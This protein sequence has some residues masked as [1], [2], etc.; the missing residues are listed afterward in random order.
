MGGDVDTD[1][2]MHTARSESEFVPVNRA[3]E[4]N[5]Y[6]ISKFVSPLAA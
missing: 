5:A 3:R 1:D 4:Q 6:H 2:T